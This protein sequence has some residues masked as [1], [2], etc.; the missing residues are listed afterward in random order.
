MSPDK[1]YRA[2]LLK[3]RFADTILK[4]KEKTLSQ[5]GFDFGLLA[6][7]FLC[8]VHFVSISTQCDLVQFDLA[9]IRGT[10]GILKNFV[11]RERNLNCRNGKV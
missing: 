5:V 4:A 1:L 8:L 10:R 3:N 2:T 9:D 7:L 6:K 11:G